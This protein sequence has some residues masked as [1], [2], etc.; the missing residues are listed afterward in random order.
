MSRLTKSGTG[1]PGCTRVVNRAVTDKVLVQ[2]HGADVDDPVGAR[3]EA[4]GLGVDDDE[5]GAGPGHGPRIAERP[6]APAGGQG[7]RGWTTG[8]GQAPAAAMAP[9][10]IVAT[11]PSNSDC[12]S[13]ALPR[14]VSVRVTSAS[15]GGAEATI[16]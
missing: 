11:S 4:G 2:P 7:S 9:A 5:L 10:A 14:R 1:M 8:S 16:T 12:P 3:V 6:V 13:P 15:P